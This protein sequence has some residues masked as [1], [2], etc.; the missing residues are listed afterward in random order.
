MECPPLQANL[1]LGP[2]GRLGRRRQASEQLMRQRG[3]RRLGQRAAVQRHLLPGVP[4]LRPEVL[5]VQVDEP[6]PRQAAEPQ[7]ERHGRVGGVVRKAAGVVQVSLLEHVG[8]VDTTIQASVQTQA[9]HL[10]QPGAVAVEQLGLG[11]FVPGAG[12][13]E[14]VVMFTLVAGP[15]R[16]PTSI[17]GRSPVSATRPSTFFTTFGADISAVRA[18]LSRPSQRL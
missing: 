6:L 3:R 4:H 5:A 2:D 16:P 15:D 10:P 9:H 7:V 11:L 13:A 8:G 18:D 17:T 14:Q 12:T 1:H